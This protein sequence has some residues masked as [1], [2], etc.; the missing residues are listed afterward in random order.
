[1]KESTLMITLG[2]LLSFLSIVLV[3]INAPLLLAGL[4]CIGG[5]MSIIS[6]LYELIVNYN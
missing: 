5:G 1:M 3:L 4:V 2:I 6:G